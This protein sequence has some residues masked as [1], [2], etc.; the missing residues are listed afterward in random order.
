MVVDR[1]RE[2]VGP[3]AKAIANEQVA[4]LVRWRLFLPY[5]RGWGVTLIGGFP[6][7][8]CTPAH[9]TVLLAREPDTVR[10]LVEW[11]QRTLG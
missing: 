8:I 7:P 10:R 5:Q 11:F 1:H 4:A 6:F 3:V 2:L 9:G